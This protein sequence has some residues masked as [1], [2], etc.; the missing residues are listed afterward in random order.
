MKE[1][2]VDS[3][4]I[5]GKEKQAEGELQEKWGQLKDKTRDVID[6][7]EDALDRDDHKDEV[8]IEER[9]RS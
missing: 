7:V 4:R 8:E 9:P 3:D 5:E 6:D 2:V 1:D